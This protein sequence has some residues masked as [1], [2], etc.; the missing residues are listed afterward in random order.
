MDKKT[1][2]TL[3]VIAVVTAI[4]VVVALVLRNQQPVEPQTELTAEEITRAD[5]PE[6]IWAEMEEVLEKPDAYFYREEGGETI[7]ALLTAGKVVGIDLNVTPNEEDGG[8]YFSI[9]YTTNGGREEELAYKLYKT[10][11]SAV[12]ADTV[13]LKMP[14]RQVGD[15]GANI[16]LLE[17]TDADIGY[18]ITPLLD[19]EETNRLYVPADSTTEGLSD[20]IYSFTYK[21]TTDGIQLLTATEK[22]SYT[23]QCVITA[24]T[25]G[26][27]PSIELLL[28]ES[29]HVT[30]WTTNAELL[31]L[32]QKTN[33]DE[34]NLNVKA[35]IAFDGRVDI[36]EAKL[37]GHIQLGQ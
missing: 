17:Q 9:H 11:A 19:T 36:L 2:I 29:L 34:E 8:M 6:S 35:T 27:Q 1:K 25:D 28:G 3:A 13:L 15:E 4:F 14:Y 10:S 7:Y 12:A 24:F 5:V 22:D 33:F 16:G 32:L 21:I 31:A 26:P 37:Y 18:Y 20:G 30:A 23:L